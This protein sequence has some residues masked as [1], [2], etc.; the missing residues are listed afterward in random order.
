MAFGTYGGGKAL[1]YTT[2]AG[3]GELHRIA[4]TGSSNQSPI[5]SVKADP[6]SGPVPLA[7]TFD[8]SA[9]RD[10]DGDTPL[11]YLWNFGNGSTKETTTPTTTHTYQTAGSYTA[12]LRVR[13]S[14]GAI[15]APDTV[16]VFPG[17]RPPNVSIDSP[18]ASKLFKVGEQITLTGSA[19]DPQDGQLSGSALKWEVRQHHNGSHYHPFLSAAGNNRTFSAPAP[20]DL[21]ATGAGNYLEIRLTAT[22]SSGLSETVTQQLRPHRV[23]VTFASRPS[24]LSVLING[25]RFTTPK[26]LVSW[27][28][29]RLNVN[30]P[31]PQTLGGT[32]YAFSSWSDGGA[33]SHTVATGAQAKT[34]TATFARESPTVKVI[35]PE[36]GSKTRDRTPTIRAKVWDASGELRAADIKLFV[37]GNRRSFRYVAGDK[38]LLSATHK[39]SRGGHTIRLMATD[40][41]KNTTNRS[42][43]FKVVVKK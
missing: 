17:N 33:R 2:Y 3:T 20:E 13:D 16:K 34:H 1:Y 10:P 9:S 22:D 25:E 37:D 23:E 39:L 38:D 15:S 18:A 7:V 43:K 36:P 4:H 24:G 29:Y 31:S 5:A 40:R 26:T 12:T 28:G 30:A 6:T 8:G 19:T 35:S 32:S 11:S 14:R 42:W 27:E 21:A 41:F